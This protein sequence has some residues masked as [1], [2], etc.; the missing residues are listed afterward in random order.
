MRQDSSWSGLPGGSGA[1]NDMV[2]ERRNGVRVLPLD[3]SA[4]V[5][6]RILLESKIKMNVREL[7]RFLVGGPGLRKEPGSGRNTCPHESEVLAY[8]ER[9]SPAYGR[10]TLDRHFAECNDCREFLALFVMA[11]RE[12]GEGLEGFMEAPYDADVMR[13]SAKV[14]TMIKEDEFQHSKTVP[15]PEKEFKREGFYLSL[16]RLAFAAALATVAVV[17]SLIWLIRADPVE[18]VAVAAL[19][20]AMKTERRTEVRISGNFE[21]SPLIVTR[22]SGESEGATDSSLHFERVFAKLKAA[23]K[24]SAPAAQRLILARAYLARNASDDAGRARKILEEVAA[25]GNE[26]A[27]IENDKGVA[28]FQLGNYEAALASF[29]RALERKPDLYEALFNT[30]LTEEK[31]KSYSDARRDWETFIR[32][33]PDA[34]WRAEAQQHL[35]P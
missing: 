25:S 27:D 33:S 9:R 30:A 18:K 8:L 20:D 12:P 2:A 31:L 29:T 1:G 26:S 19:G 35:T 14:L 21:Y 3:S 5:A 16:P 34:R 28:W 22:G 11:S 15:A 6:L 10:H 13:Q 17:G 32:V 4:T 24:P 23:E 7:Y